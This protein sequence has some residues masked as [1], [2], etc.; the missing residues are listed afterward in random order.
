M[1]AIILALT[2]V[3]AYA[4]PVRHDWPY[5]RGSDQFSHAVMAQQMLAH[6][7]YGTYMIYPP[8]FSA[9]TA[10]ICR[11]SGLT[12]LTLFP[13]LA[14]AL[15]VLTTL[16]AYALA[17]R[18]WGWEY[19]LAAA[20]LSGLVLR[21]PYAS[22]AEGRY[23]DLT[24]AYF[25]LMMLVAALITLLAAPSVRSGLLVAVTGAAVV[26]YHSVASLYLAL[27]LAA[28]AAVGLPYLLARR[29]L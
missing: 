14:P 12:P 6:G 29:R 22:F 11:V 3:R 19:G 4:G 10:A 5:L 25:L 16:A 7:S 2:A 26:L 8:G 28:V 9:L 24:A 21:G 15:L 23:P 27:L 13:V 20:A 17:T 1:L 18:L